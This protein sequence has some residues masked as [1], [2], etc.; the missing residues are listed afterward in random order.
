MDFDFG[1]ACMGL[2]GGAIAGA[3]LGLFTGSWFVFFIFLILGFCSGAFGEN[4]FVGAVV[5]LIAGIVIGGIIAL[6]VSSWK[7]S[8]WI[9]TIVA[10]VCTAVGE[11]FGIYDDISTNKENKRKKKAEA[12]EAQKNA[13][14]QDRRGCVDAVFKKFY[15]PNC[16]N[17]DF[18]KIYDHLAKTKYGKELLTSEKDYIR[19]KFD[20]IAPSYLKEFTTWFV[21]HKCHAGDLSLWFSDLVTLPNIGNKYEPLLAHKDYFRENIWGKSIFTD[22]N[23]VHEVIEDIKTRFRRLY[24]EDN[25]SDSEI[26]ENVYQIYLQRWEEI[27]RSHKS[28]KYFEAAKLILWSGDEDA[29]LLE[30]LKSLLI[31]DATVDNKSQYELERSENIKLLYSWYF[32]PLFEEKVKKDGKVVKKSYYY[33]TVDSIIAEAI[34]YSRGGIV[35][36][37]NDEIVAVLEKLESHLDISQY[38]ALRKGFEYLKAYDQEKIVLNKMFEFNLPRTPEQEA[39]LAYLNKG[40]QNTPQIITDSG[41]DGEMLYDYRSMKWKDS[42]IR[43]YFDALTMNSTTITLP[44]VVDEWQQNLTGNNVKWDI[45]AVEKVIAES[46]SKNFGDRFTVSRVKAGAAT[47]TGSFTEPSIYIQERDREASA[48]PYL[49]FVVTGDQMMLSQINLAVYALFNP[50]TDEVTAAN[51]AKKNTEFCSAM[52][53]IK[54]KQNPKLNNF[55]TTFKNV[56]IQ[57]LENW[58]N[59]KNE[60]SI[61][62]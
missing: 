6:I 52:I 56:L 49:S 22:C 61:Y 14:I 12:E 8:W 31:F 62:D 11:G 54:E 27:E 13:L 1:G 39:R 44:M 29:T 17:R 32:A 51:R 18:S 20:F 33:Q 50:D 9:F 16:G 41:E 23:S 24:P 46:L 28:G 36:Q 40:V 4:V 59:N 45:K 55:I 60:S 48:F 47:E 3:I 43:S 26:V 53:M 42:D 5:G 34:C 7:T 37:L 58:F 19:K 25:L 38:E 10:I 21:N 15:G 30:I 35:N 57:E 2:F